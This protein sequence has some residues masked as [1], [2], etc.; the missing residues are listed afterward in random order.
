MLLLDAVLDERGLLDRDERGVAGS[1]DL[2]EGIADTGE[3]PDDHQ[4]GAIY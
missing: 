1:E 3:S 4:Q 2:S